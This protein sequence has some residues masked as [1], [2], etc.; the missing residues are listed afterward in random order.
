MVLLALV[1]MV[2]YI[3]V[4]GYQGYHKSYPAYPEQQTAGQTIDQAVGKA[5]EKYEEVLDREQNNPHCTLSNC[6]ISSKFIPGV[7]ENRA[8]FTNAELVNFRRWVTKE[9]PRSSIDLYSVSAN[10][11]GVVEAIVYVTMVKCTSPEND[12]P[13]SS[14]TDVHRMILIPSHHHEADYVVMEDEYFPMMDAMKYP[15]AFSPLYAS[16][17]DEDMFPE[18]SEPGSPHRF[19]GL[20]RSFTTR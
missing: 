7:P 12:Y 11:N 14:T 10:E 9:K 19:A 1:A 16:S 13:Y 18:C 20:T 2:G 4:S 17:E 15:A 5:V 3:A 8:L 6:P